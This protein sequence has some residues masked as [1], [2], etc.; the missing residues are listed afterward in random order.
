[1]GS[2]PARR[3]SSSTG[4]KKSQRRA[5]RPALGARLTADVAPWRPF[6][7][8]GLLLRPS[9]SKRPAT[10]IF[11]ACEREL[12][13]HLSAVCL[14]PA[15]ERNE[16]WR[17]GDYSFYI[18]DFAP[19]PKAR[20]HVQFW[21]EPD[22]D[23]VLFEVVPAA[24]TGG[25]E[26]VATTVQTALRERGFE[27]GGNA[28]HFGKTV[29]V[30][31]VKDVRALARE[32]IAILSGVLGYDGTRELNY[33]LSLETESDVRHVL[34]QIEPEDLAKLLREW[35]V[36]AEL[37]P[38]VEGEPPQIDCR[39]E[40]APF[41]VLLSDE[42]AEGS[43]SYLSLALRTFHSLPPGTDEQAEAERLRIANELNY[44][45]PSLQASVDD[46][47]DL[48]LDSSILLHGGVTAEHL[49]ARF[50]LWRAMLQAMG[51]EMQ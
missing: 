25:A 30:A 12:L 1:M 7:D 38:R 37:K 16:T 21:S 45:F 50:E 5:S 36:P 29:R 13:A 10:A 28:R 47:G 44:T 9:K 20:A 32:S 19:A 49:R 31:G 26:A 42:A 23:G 33:T 27:I 6:K 48:V 46:D 18:L 8:E 40:T 43:D 35:G 24:S 15:K 17:I 22:S 39:S 14:W 11:A 51:E 3:K 41:A 2:A 4:K 34:M